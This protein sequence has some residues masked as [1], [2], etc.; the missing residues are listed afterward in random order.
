MTDLGITTQGG[1][2][3]PRCTER[4]FVRGSSISDGVV[5]YNGTSVGSRA[6]Y[7]CNDGSVLMGNEATRVCQCDGNW[8]GSV[9]QCMQEEGSMCCSQF[10][11]ITA[12]RVFCSY[13]IFCS[14]F[15]SICMLILEVVKELV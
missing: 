12:Y 3:D 5:C 10:R 15:N 14:L 2:V 6:V 11:I 13:R 1:T 9:P 7:I 4:G 8:N